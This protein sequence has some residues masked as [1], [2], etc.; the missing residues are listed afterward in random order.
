MRMGYDRPTGARLQQNSYNRIIWHWISKLDGRLFCQRAEQILGFS[1]RFP[2]R[3]LFT[4][5]AHFFI[6]PRNQ[7]QA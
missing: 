5:H 3:L 1:P 7:Q 4:A 2:L 6:A